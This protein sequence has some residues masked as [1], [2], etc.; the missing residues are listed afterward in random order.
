MQRPRVRLID[1]ARAAGCSP[2]AV[3]RVFAGKAAGEVGEELGARIRALAAELGYRSNIAARAL[4]SGSTRTVGMVLGEIANGYYAA[5]A[6]LALLE[7]MRHNYQLLLSLTIWKQEEELHCLENLYARQAD[8]ILYYPNLELQTGPLLDQLEKSRFPLLLADQH[9]TRFNTI[10]NDAS[11]G[12]REA[13]RSLKAAGHGAVFGVMD[14]RPGWR[15]PLLEAGR[16]EGVAIAMTNLRPGPENRRAIIAGI[17]AERPGAI[18]LRARLTTEALLREI[19]AH[20]PDYHPAIVA[21]HELSTPVSGN[22]LLR[23]VLRV[24]TKTFA[25]TAMRRVIELAESPGGGEICR[26]AVPVRY[27]PRARF[28]EIEIKEE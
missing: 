21:D 24:D 8:G 5:F 19:A 12:M 7:A 18:I 15:E 10:F 16:E 14:S 27:L 20:A 17:L 23:G 13:V 3:S 22:P 4:R 28:G 1:V 6:E 11:E 25:E 9:S 26:L 2:M